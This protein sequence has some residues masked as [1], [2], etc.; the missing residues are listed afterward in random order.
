VF[1]L[2]EGVLFG[3]NIVHYSKLHPIVYFK[4]VVGICTCIIDIIFKRISLVSLIEIT[5]L[6]IINFVIYIADRVA[7]SV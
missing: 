5:F 2:Y 4:V 6:I 1:L 3:S 7:Q